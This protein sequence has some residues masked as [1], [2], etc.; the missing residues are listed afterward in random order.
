MNYEELKHGDE[1]P[2]KAGKESHFTEKELEEEN[3]KYLEY[4]YNLAL[5]IIQDF[6]ES[7][8]HE[9]EYAD[10][11]AAKQAIVEYQE[12]Y[13]QKKNDFSE[14]VIE[15]LKIQSDLI[16]SLSKEL[17]KIKDSLSPE[18]IEML[19]VKELAQIYNIK[20]GQQK[21]LRGR[22]FNPLPF[23]Q[24]KP[25]SKI[26]YKREE[27]EEWVSKQKVKRDT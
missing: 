12:I 14:E 20:E 26:T 24:E 7:V 11:I 15:A 27:I 13:I 6:Q 10:Y 16:V 5:E 9:E 1:N 23:H 3:Q 22:L 4:E 18:K 8:L 2:Y 19:N 21:Q 25:G 17:K